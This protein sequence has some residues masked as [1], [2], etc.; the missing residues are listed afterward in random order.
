MSTT[1]DKVKTILAL[2]AL[3]IALGFAGAAD[4]EPGPADGAANVRGTR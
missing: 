4:N 3:L 2:I 1:S